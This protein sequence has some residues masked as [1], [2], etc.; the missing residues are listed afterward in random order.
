M[1]EVDSRREKA[2]QMIAY[3]DNVEIPEGCEFIP[4][5]KINDGKKVRTKKC[6]WIERGASGVENMEAMLHEVV[7]IENLFRGQ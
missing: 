5:H 1:S 2:E 7:H 3:F 4:G 6:G